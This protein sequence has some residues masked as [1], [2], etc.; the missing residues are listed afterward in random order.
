[1]SKGF[2]Q[3]RVITVNNCPFLCNHKKQIDTLR[4]G[5]EIWLCSLKAVQ[6]MPPCADPPEQ[7]RYLSDLPLPQVLV[8]SLQ[9]PQLDQVAKSASSFQKYDRISGCQ[10]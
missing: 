3:M 9:G 5:S 7:D 6:P 4:G 10:D 2:Q 8:H 1:M